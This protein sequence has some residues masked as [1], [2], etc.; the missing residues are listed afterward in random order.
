M[1]FVDGYALDAG[2]VRVIRAT[3]EV[4]LEKPPGI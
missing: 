3:K 2:P 1:H 4:E